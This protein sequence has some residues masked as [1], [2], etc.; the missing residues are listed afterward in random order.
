MKRFS[1]WPGILSQ[2]PDSGGLLR[3][4]KGSFVGGRGRVSMSQKFPVTKTPWLVNAGKGF[5]TCD[6]VDI[7]ILSHRLP[8]SA[9][10]VI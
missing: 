9:C 3:A 1:V 2:C 8:E 4:G 10:S 5:G 7:L 6:G